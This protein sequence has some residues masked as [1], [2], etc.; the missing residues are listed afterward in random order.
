M[1]FVLK[2]A[3]AKHKH[4]LCNRD[5]FS[6]ER[7]RTNPNT[8]RPIFAQMGIQPPKVPHKVHKAALTCSK[9]GL[10][11]F[12]RKWFYCSNELWSRRV[13]SQAC[14]LQQ[15]PWKQPLPR[16]RIQ[17]N[18]L[19]LK[20]LMDIIGYQSSPA[21]IM[22]DSTIWTAFPISTPWAHNLAAAL[23]SAAFARA[24]RY[25]FSSGLGGRSTTKFIGFGA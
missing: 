1:G 18:F 20:L 8:P 16:M 11:E 5:P 10:L 2:V 17:E 22:A 12:V 3:I 24:F 13:L 14:E 6:S 23:Y 9:Q 4:P 21:S 25:R 15:H 19:F 7:E